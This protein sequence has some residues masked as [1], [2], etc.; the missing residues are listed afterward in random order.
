[1]DTIKLN[2]GEIK[3][4]DKVFID[5]NI[6]KQDTDVLFAYYIKPH[7]K[8]NILVNYRNPGDFFSMKKRYFYVTKSLDEGY[9][10]YTKI[11]QMYPELDSIELK[12]WF[13]NMELIQNKG[14]S[15]SSSLQKCLLK[16]NIN[17]IS[18]KFIIPVYIS[19][20]LEKYI[21]YTGITE[22]ELI[23][24]I[25]KIL[26]EQCNLSNYFG[27][28]YLEFIEK[29][30]QNKRTELVELL[31]KKNQTNDLEKIFIKLKPK[32]GLKLITQLF[33]KKEYSSIQYYIFKESL[34]PS[35]REEFLPKMIEQIHSFNWLVSYED[36]L[37]L[38]EGKIEITKFQYKKWIQNS[39]DKVEMFKKMEHF[40]DFRSKKD[41]IISMIQNCYS[42][43][44]LNELFKI[45]IN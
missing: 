19:N 2:Q 25:E 13:V 29:V 35:Q 33:D 42:D 36:Y 40:I 15:M 17:R 7:G 32:F 45:F 30:I 43:E 37:Q 12:M 3:V 23:N 24:L 5:S 14:H 34:T 26:N 44:S 39:K 27:Y 4:T 20:S 10:L 31:I 22:D 16:Y 41:V 28:N 6:L 38:F 1:M 21:D 11:I 9:T 8:K 18:Y